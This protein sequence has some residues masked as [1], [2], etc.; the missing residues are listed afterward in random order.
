MPPIWDKTE[1]D[2]DGIYKTVERHS[3]GMISFAYESAPSDEVL[4]ALKDTE[5]F[6]SVVRPSLN[7]DN[8]LTPVEGRKSQA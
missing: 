2:S 8:V 3:P 6:K 7:G 4:E 5:T 1:N